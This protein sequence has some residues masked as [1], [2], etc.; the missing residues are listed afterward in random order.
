MQFIRNKL[1]D[2]TVY[3]VLVEH[4]SIYQDMHKA[5]CKPFAVCIW[6]VD[7]FRENYINTIKMQDR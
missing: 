5:A 4:K 2:T 6:M 7:I 3:I 1:L